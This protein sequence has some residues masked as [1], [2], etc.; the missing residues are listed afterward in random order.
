ML[1]KPIAAGLLASMRQRSLK[2]PLQYQWRRT[3]LLARE[4]AAFLPA[5]ARPYTRQAIE[6]DENS[7]LREQNANETGMLKSDL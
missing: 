7:A 5:A 4:H 6:P 3:R 2:F 1:G